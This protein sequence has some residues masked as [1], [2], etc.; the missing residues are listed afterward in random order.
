MVR[1]KFKYPK[2]GI[3]VPQTEAYLIIKLAKK[4]QSNKRS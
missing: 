3:P 1:Q 2:V 4:N